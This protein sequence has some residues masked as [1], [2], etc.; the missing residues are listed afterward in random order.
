MDIMP[1]ITLQTVWLVLVALALLVAV[2]VLVT[3]PSGN[4]TVH[5]IA[6]RC[7]SGPRLCA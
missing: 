3:S 4:P 5:K 2:M 6:P 1:F 7:H